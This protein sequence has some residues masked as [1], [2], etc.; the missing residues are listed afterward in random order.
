MAA[1]AVAVR[2]SFAKLSWK[3][4]VAVV[5]VIVGSEPSDSR[6]C[7]HLHPASGELK[8][9]P[10]SRCYRPCLPTPFPLV[11]AHPLRRIRLASADVGLCPT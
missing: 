2:E 5:V 7:S 10:A 4:V 1:C 8:H 3:A 6:C 11:S 9:R